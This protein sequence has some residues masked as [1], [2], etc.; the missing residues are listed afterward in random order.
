MQNLLK[1]LETVLRKEVKFVSDDGRLLKNSIIEAGLRLD[2]S[3]LKLLVENETIKEVFFA[4]VDSTLVFDKFEFQKFVSNKQFLKDSYTSFKNK[5]G[6]SDGEDGYLKQRND[7]VLNWAY[8][9]CVLEGGMTKKDKGRKEIFYNTTL[10]PDEITRLYAPKVFTNFEKWDAAAVKG[11]KAKKVTEIKS[12]DNLLIKGNNLLALHCLK[13]RY[14]GKVKLIY[15]DPPYNTGKAGDS[16]AYNNSF[17]HSTWLTFM[18]NRLEAAKLLL[19]KDGIIVIDIDHNELFYLGVMCDEIFGVENRLGVL[20]VQHNP[21]GRDAEFFAVSNENKIIY[22]ANKELAE[23][24]G[25]PLT[26]DDIKQFTKEDNISKYKLTGLI[27]TGDNSRKEDRENMYFPIFYNKETKDISVYPMTGQ[28]WIEMFPIDNQGIRRI[29]RWGKE[30][31]KEKWRN[32]IV[33]TENRGKYQIKV[34]D[35]LTPNRRKN[36]KTLWLDSKYAGTK[37]TT[38]VKEIF[39]EKIFTYPKSPFQVADVLELTTKEGDLILDFFG[40]S[41]TTFDVA[42]KMGRQWI[43]VEQI[44]YEKD[45]PESRIKEVINGDQTGISKNVNWIGGGEF[46]Y[47]ELK[48]WNE[49]Y[50]QEARKVKTK[51][52][53]KKLYRAIKQ[54]AFYRYDA[55][56]KIFNT[57]K[58]N[59]LSL[60][61]Q[62]KALCNCLDFNHLYVNYSERDDAK[63]KVTKDEK[64]LTKKLYGK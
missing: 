10:A 58:F 34:K 55:D 64:E 6:L 14:A 8:K 17:S 50:I 20:S 22:A 26:N 31:V 52:D 30:T 46:I 41:G 36:S 32:E 2:P 38:A 40:G 63:Y 18:K 59:A 56:M 37:G 39:G 21:G 51:A 9:D 62:K 1:E 12:T 24:Y 60:D 49:K 29:W 15:I 48:E 19:K 5:I 7:V 11:G 53:I 3:L 57:K 35:R 23:L 61:D 28:P 45:L 47:C 13:E 4:E 16:F 27:R 54:E 33:V 42:H 44:N 43:G 25:L